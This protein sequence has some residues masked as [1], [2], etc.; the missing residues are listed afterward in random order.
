M[1]VNDE[2]DVEQTDDADAQAQLLGVLQDD[3][4]NLIGDGEGRIDGDGV[5][6]VDA[7]TLDQLHD[8]GDEDVAAVTDGVDLDLAALDILVDQNGLVLVDLNGG[9]QV[10]AQLLLVGHDLHGT[11]TQNEG[12][13]NQNGIADLPDGSNAVLNP[14][15]CLTLCTGDIQLIEQI[16]E[17]IA[18]KLPASAGKIRHRG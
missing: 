15:H 9:A 18:V 12:G 1:L 7:G 5:T 10:V 17:S 16:F 2:L 3:T 8:A 13:A 14:G 11:A 6:G 4:L